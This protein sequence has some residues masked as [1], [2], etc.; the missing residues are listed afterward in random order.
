MHESLFTLI[1]TKTSV[2]ILKD[3]SAVF[4]HF[5]LLEGN[6]LPMTSQIVYAGGRRFISH[7][8]VISESD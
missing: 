1:T 7:M 5:C 4:S 8:K 2:V 3:N 6:V